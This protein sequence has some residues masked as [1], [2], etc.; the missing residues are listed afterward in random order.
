MKPYGT[1]A[2]FLLSCAIVTGGPA[3]AHAAETRA[4]DGAPGEE[5]VF[6][7]RPVDAK[8]KSARREAIRAIARREALRQ[9]LPYELAD[10]IIRVE[11]EYNPRARGGAGEYGLM[12]IMPPTA[13]M[14]GFSGDFEELYDPEVNI[15]LGV[16]YLAEAWRKGGQDICTMAM[17]YRAGHGETR[18][19]VKSVDYCNR[20]RTHLASI[21]YPVTG[22]VP[23][24]TF[25]FNDK[26]P[27]WGF[28]LGTKAAARRLFTGKKLR[29]R[30]NWA[31]YDARMN[32]LIARGRVGLGN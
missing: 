4:A 22:E 32:A 8:A 15:P 11:S 21:N 3:P 25:G 31:A 10:A 1:F 7:L 29:S 20:V 23:A 24:A 12:Q 9:G 26:G 19:S 30:V 16:R 6:Q 5:Q 17:K 18:F 13:R 27:A 2:A 14:L 28:G